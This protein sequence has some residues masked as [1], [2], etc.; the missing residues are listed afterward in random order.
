VLAAEEQAFRAVNDLP[1][2]LFGALWLPMQMG[3]KGVALAA[4]VMTRN[5][6]AVVAIPAAVITARIVKH[7]VRR[8]RPW[9]L[10][11]QVQ[12]R[13]EPDLAGYGFV[14]G[15]AAVAAAGFGWPAGLVV[16]LCR[17]YVGAHSPAD[18]VGGVLLG[19][20]L[21]RIFVG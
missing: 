10:M 12:R 17:V 9:S 20:A 4:A 15:H 8:P 18:V 19:A 7:V 3:N 21:R 2:G 14:S 5:R 6:G 13:G 16:G 11:S 1:D